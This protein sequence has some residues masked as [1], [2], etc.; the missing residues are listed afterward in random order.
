[1]CMWI[2]QYMFP[3]DPQ[4]AVTYDNMPQYTKKTGERETEDCLQVNIYVNNA[5]SVTVLLCNFF[6]RKAFHMF[7]R[8][9]EFTQHIL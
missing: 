5:K 7:V 6:M 8:P 2:M 1:M 4:L 9:Q 3:T